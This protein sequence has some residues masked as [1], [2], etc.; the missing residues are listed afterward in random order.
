M[1]EC[2]AHYTNLARKTDEFLSSLLGFIGHRVTLE[3]ILKD[4]SRGF[5]CDLKINV[6]SRSFEDHW[7][8]NHQKVVKNLDEE[9]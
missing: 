6:T 5:P 7:S 2:E 3:E 8:V 9:N 1:T 4:Y